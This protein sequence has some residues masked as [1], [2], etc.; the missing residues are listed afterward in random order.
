VLWI[1]ECF[2]SAAAAVALQDLSA[3]FYFFFIT[4]RAYI[5]IL[6]NNIQY[7]TI[8]AQC[9]RA[10]TMFSFARANI[11][12]YIIIAVADRN[13]RKPIPDDNGARE[14]KKTAPSGRRRYIR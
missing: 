8:R 1:F 10:L 5:Y 6:Y 12:Y 14:K 4:D 9:H 7:R 2:G 11:Y 13:P 3:G